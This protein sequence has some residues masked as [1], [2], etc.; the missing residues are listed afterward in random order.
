MIEKN[1]S[2]YVRKSIDANEDISESSLAC[3]GLELL[4]SGEETR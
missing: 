4:K 3:Y 1:R 2:L